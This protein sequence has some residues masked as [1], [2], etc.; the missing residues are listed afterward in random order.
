[1]LDREINNIYNS[2][3]KQTKQGGVKML[4]KVFF[5]GLM[6]MM[7]PAAVFAL[8]IDGTQTQGKGTVSVGV[9]TEY[10][11]KRDLATKNKPVGDN[12]NYSS[13]KITDLY[14]VYVRP[15]I[16]I[17]DGVDLYAKLGITDYDAKMKADTVKK[18]WD[19]KQAFLGGAG[20]KI[21]YEITQ[22]LIW[23]ADIGFAYSKNSGHFSGASQRWTMYEWH[24]APY[25]G[26]LIGNFVPY[27][28]VKYDDM[29][30]KARTSSGSFYKYRAEDQ[31]GAFLGV[32]YGIGEKVCVN[33]E[34]RFVD[35]VGLS[36]SVNYRF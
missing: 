13:E 2:S 21:S 27:V 12:A 34:G 4:K 15:S 5:F 20:T 26:K 33:A 22:G 30:I 11:I 9:G 3:N 32:D 16:G 35:E 6:V 36:L 29:R 1:V 8:S 25:I 18:E 23:G 17:I 10:L 14:R 19:A 7:A 28:G 31:V 24:I